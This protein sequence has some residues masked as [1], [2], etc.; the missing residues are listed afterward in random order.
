M[1]ATNTDFRFVLS[2]WTSQQGVLLGDA[3]GNDGHCALFRLW[4]H[5][6]IHAMDGNLGLDWKW[7]ERCAAWD[8]ARPGRF[9]QVSLEIGILKRDSHGQF[10]L[11]GWIENQGSY[12]AHAPTRS[13]KAKAAVDSRWAN[14]K[15]V[16][17][18]NAGNATNA[19]NDGN[20]TN[21]GNAKSTEP[22]LFDTQDVKEGEKQ[23]FRVSNTP[24]PPPFPLPLPDPTPLP[25]PARANE[26]RR[27]VSRLA[28]AFTTKNSVVSKNSFKPDYGAEWQ[29]ARMILE[30]HGWP[31][32]DAEQA[33][34]WIQRNIR[35]PNDGPFYRAL[36]LGITAHRKK[37][38]NKIAFM[39]A[40]VYEPN[41]D[42]FRA[43]R[44][45]F[46]DLM[47]K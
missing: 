29:C 44:K 31:P 40:E 33:V 32:L 25:S 36:A 14:E 2:Y 45:E 22:S 4:S 1:A 39:Q 17:V 38:R 30:R 26:T 27:E 43:V 6:A 18:T 16:N 12:A 23:P 5:A 34:Q 13:A 10:H 11:N 42:I 46:D 8:K 20:A 3:L 15:A 35:V 41:D 47:A 19:R 9:V 37:V 21:A 24:S 28:A 7:I